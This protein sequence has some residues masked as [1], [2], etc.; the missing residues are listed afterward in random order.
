LA[1][2]G[3]A[4]ALVGSVG[5]AEEPVTITLIN[6]ATVSGRVVERTEVGITLESGRRTRMYPWVAVAPGSRFRF[7]GFYRANLPELLAGGAEA[8][9]APV[10]DADSSEI[11]PVD[12][13]LVAAVLAADGRF[14]F[15]AWS[16]APPLDLATIPSLAAQRG[17]VIRF[18][19]WQSG[20]AADAATLFVFNRDDPGN[21]VVY[22]PTAVR[23]F[24]ES[25]TPRTVAGREYLSFPPRQV[26]SLIGDLEMS[27]QVQWLV[28]PADPEQR[29]LLVDLTL[30]HRGREASAQ[31]SGIP[32][33]MADGMD[34]LRPRPLV[35]PPTLLF[36]V[37]AD[38]SLPVLRGQVRVGRLSMLPRS[39]FGL[40]VPVEVT[41][42]TGRVVLKHALAFDANTPPGGFPLQFEMA[43]L[44]PGGT[45]RLTASMDMGGF[46]DNIAVDETFIL[47]EVVQEP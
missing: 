27:E 22:E 9:H 20:P 36:A 37:D 14:P 12:G 45:Y 19:A 15:A 35:V 5:R 2:L 16:N 30:K 17:P 39:G 3:V 33:G 29:F 26:T 18:W 23:S 10:E 24:T 42:R 40:T 34:P 47:P 8:T 31:L 4:L 25:A 46:F 38:G 6:G 32:P 13:S 28:S 21:L 7:D 44:D 1:L 41:D 43:D 11:G